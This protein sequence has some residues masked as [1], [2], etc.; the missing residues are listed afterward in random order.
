MGY[1]RQFGHPI[2][3]QHGAIEATGHRVRQGTA[4]GCCAGENLLQCAQIIGIDQG[5]FGQ[6]KGDRRHNPHAPGAVV[7]ANTQEKLQL[8]PR[9]GD[10]NTAT[11]EMHIHHHG[12]TID[13]KEGQ[14]GG[15][16]LTGSKFSALGGLIDIHRKVAM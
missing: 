1:G 12:H 5:M 3:L 8:E 10:Q 6:C 15:G 14:E 13:V 7:L 4:H 16:G 11:G 2:A 9:H